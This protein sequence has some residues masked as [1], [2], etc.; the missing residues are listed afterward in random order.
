M[1][2]SCQKNA[3]WFDAECSSGR[4]SYLEALRSFNLV[5]IEENQS[6]LC[7]HR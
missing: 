6:V 1:N 7:S 2:D 4:R 5:K 3:E